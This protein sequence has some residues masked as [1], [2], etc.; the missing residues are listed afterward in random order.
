[1]LSIKSLSSVPRLRDWYTSRA[2]IVD[3]VSFGRGSGGSRGGLS[4]WDAVEDRCSGVCGR[5]QGSARMTA[6]HERSLAWPG[7][8]RR[9]DETHQIN[10]NFSPH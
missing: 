5:G 8:R 2:R 3:T 7:R 1:V 10:P 6:V 9:V 4:D